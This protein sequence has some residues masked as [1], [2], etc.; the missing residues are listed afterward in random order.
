[1]RQLRILLLTSLFLPST[2]YSQD[3][4]PAPQPTNTST[5][6][7]EAW[8]RLSFVPGD[9]E[10][11]IS[12]KNGKFRC[13]SLSITD[14]RLSCE[15][16][17]VFGSSRTVYV[18][19]RKVLRVRERLGDGNSGIAIVAAVAGGFVW[20]HSWDRPALHTVDGIVVGTAFGVAAWKLTAVALHFLPGK[21]IY[22][23]PAKALDA[24]QGDTSET[25]PTR[26]QSKLAAP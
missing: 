13:E 21:T 20:A 5:T 3:L 8:D 9:E 1:M 11:F 18:P 17:S 19:R 23:H 15:A 10:V 16:Y 12:S 14:Q 4:P 6:D 2:L 24:Q 26:A 7:D 22:R 25:V